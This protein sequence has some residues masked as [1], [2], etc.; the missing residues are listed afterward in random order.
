MSQGN[1][2]FLVCKPCEMQ[3]NTDF[4]VKIA[5]RTQRSYYEHMAPIAQFDAWLRKHAKCGG[6][7]NPDHFQLGYL[8]AHNHDQNELEAAV[9]MALVQ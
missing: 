5:G 2:L 3:K 9:K 4:G 8:S 7:T 1:I 6:R